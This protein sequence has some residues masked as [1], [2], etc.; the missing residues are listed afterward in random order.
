MPPTTGKD[1]KD[2]DPTVSSKKVLGLHSIHKPTNGL[3][4][5]LRT[6]KIASR[7]SSIYVNFPSKA[8]GYEHEGGNVS[9]KKHFRQLHKHCIL[10]QAPSVAA[11]TVGGRGG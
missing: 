5:R 2:L 3:L 7:H 8:P 4:I 6:K 11:D 1:L 10:L 9:A